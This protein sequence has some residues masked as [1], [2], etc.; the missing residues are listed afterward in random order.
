[1]SKL[2]GAPPITV[3]TALDIFTMVAEISVLSALEIA[4]TAV[5]SDGNATA[6]TDD[7]DATWLI[8]RY[9]S[10]ETAPL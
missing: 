4:D 9:I 7:T 8:R 10:V 1:M 6:M 5:E 3:E 2:A